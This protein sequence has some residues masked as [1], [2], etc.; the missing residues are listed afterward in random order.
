MVCI[1]KS[2]RLEKFDLE[3]RCE[4]LAAP[5]SGDCNEV[6]KIMARGKILKKKKKKKGI[7]LFRLSDGMVKNILNVYYNIMFFHQKVKKFLVLKPYINIYNT[8]EQQI[9]INL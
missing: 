7:L 2:N 8:S 5:Q 9:F 3:A 1:G 4:L 6:N